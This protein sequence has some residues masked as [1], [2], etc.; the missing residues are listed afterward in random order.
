MPH[1]A[2]TAC[3]AASVDGFLATAKRNAQP[4]SSHLQP[5]QGKCK[6]T[7]DYVNPLGFFMGAMN[8]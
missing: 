7:W 6:F 3:R 4:W 5:L 2:Q 8:A 1:E